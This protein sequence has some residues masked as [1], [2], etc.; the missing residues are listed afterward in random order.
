MFNVLI[1]F[2]FIL[3]ISFFLS[4]LVFYKMLSDKEKMSCFECGLD[5]S[6]CS[7]LRFCMKFFLV[8]IVFLVFDVEV[9]L[10]LPLPFSYTFFI[11]FIFVLL[12]GLIYE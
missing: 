4:C 11:L 7:R 9:C 10:L 5:P 12:L 1:F 8:G 2:C 3:F 6:G